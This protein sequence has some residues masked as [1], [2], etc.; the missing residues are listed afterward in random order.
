MNTKNV[1]LSVFILLTILFASLT[2]ME[3]F[4]IGTM[5]TTTTE[6]SMTTSIQTRTVVTQTSY[7]VTETVTSNRILGQGLW[8]LS[9]APGCGVSASPHSTS[10]P[11]PCFGP[12][13]DAHLFNCAVSANTTQ[14]CTQRINITGNSNQSFTMTVWFP[15]FNYTVSSWQNCKYTVPSVPLTFGVGPYYAYCISVNPA[16]FLISLPAP[17]PV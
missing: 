11:V 5:T 2:V 7:T 16:S 13:S 17:G 1:V 3:H 14:G 6:L 12:N 15:Y 8:Y 4:E 9:A 10:Y